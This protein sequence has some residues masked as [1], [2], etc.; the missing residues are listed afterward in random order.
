MCVS[1][2]YVYMY[3]ER[4]GCMCMHVFMPQVIVINKILISVLG[5]SWSCLALTYGACCASIIASF[6]LLKCEMN[7][8]RQEEHLSESLRG[9]RRFLGQYLHLVSLSLGCSVC[10]SYVES[11][12]S[13]YHTCLRSVPFSSQVLPLLGHPCFAPDGSW[14]IL[15]LYLQ[16]AGV[17]QEGLHC[18]DAE[19]I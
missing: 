14:G 12:H 1:Y 3:K 9:C 13:G 7:Q 15:G 10:S 4:D 19:K 5:E 11:L 16:P 17:V 6:W 8:S 18:F 2:I